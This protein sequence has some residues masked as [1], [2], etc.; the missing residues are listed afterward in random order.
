MFHVKHFY[1]GGL[2]RP[3]RSPK[4][5]S[6][7]SVVVRPDHERL[8]VLKIGICEG[9]RRLSDFVVQ[10]LAFQKHHL[11]AGGYQTLGHRYELL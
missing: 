9:L 11:T 3:Q 8:N 4:H 6:L 1:S 10:T 7:F 5:P 2:G